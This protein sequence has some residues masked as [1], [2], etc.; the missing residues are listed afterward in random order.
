VP[1]D[2]VSKP[3]G[4]TVPKGNYRVNIQKQPDSTSVFKVFTDSMI[5][6]YRRYGV[7]SLQHDDLNV[8]RGGFGVSNHDLSAKQFDLDVVLP[9]GMSAY[10]LGECRLSMQNLTVEQDD[11]VSLSILDP[12]YDIEPVVRNFG[13]H[14]TTYDV[15]LV[16]YWKGKYTDFNTDKYEHHSVILEANSSQT[17]YPKWRDL[18]GHSV[19]I[20]ID[21][22][23]DGT[24]DSTVDLSD[25]TTDVKDHN[26]DEKPQA[27]ALLQNYP[28]PFNPITT[29]S[30]LLPTQSHVTLKVF[31]L[32]GR[33]VA[34]LVDDYKEAGYYEA[35][36]DA[37]SL[38]GGVYY[39]RLQAGTFTETKK[40]L[41]MK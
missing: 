18:N 11:S 17:L 9:I 34:T 27:Y 13:S 21:N 33:E 37:S 15:K 1:A 12:A 7:D 2:I 38:S 22:G 29:I 31:D 40:L 4:Y 28:N 19:Q 26:S 23:N 20:D 10:Y 35:S 8:D 25:Q 30:Y 6:S 16:S 24:V 32:L 41:L 3:L 36:F 14:P 39:Y 5:Y